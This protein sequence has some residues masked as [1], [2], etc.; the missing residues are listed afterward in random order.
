MRFTMS[1][2]PALASSLRENEE[3]IED[4]CR[5]AE[6]VLTESQVRRKWHL[7]DEVWELLGTDESYVERVEIQRVQRLRSGR[8]KRELAQLHVVAAP[9]ILNGIMSDPKANSRHRIDAAKGLND[10]ADFAPQRPGVET[11]KVII[12]IDMGADVRARGLESNPADVLHIE[13]EVRPRDADGKIIEPQEQPPLIEQFE[14]EVV[15]QK[16][17]RGRPRGSRNKP[18][19]TEP[20][21]RPRR[22]PGFEV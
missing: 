8:A 18:K 13:A 14:R 15:S 12:H 11:E 4:L 3:L 20:E 10:L 1:S 5:Y 21:S 2:V 9:G 17:G 7:E 22:V 19:A 16:R 6:G